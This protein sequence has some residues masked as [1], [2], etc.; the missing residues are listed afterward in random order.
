MK[1]LKY[2]RKEKL[3]IKENEPIFERKER[4]KKKH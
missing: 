2:I 3:S 4:E 1:F